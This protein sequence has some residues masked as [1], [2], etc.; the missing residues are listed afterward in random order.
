VLFAR[1]SVGFAVCLGRYIFF[2]SY[3]SSAVYSPSSAQTRIWEWSSV[4]R[5]LLGNP[6]GKINLEGYPVYGMIIL[7][8]ILQKSIR[9]TQSGL[10]WLEIGRNSNL[11]LSWYWNS[12]FRQMR[13]VASVAE[14]PIDF[15]EGL[16]SVC[17]V[18]SLLSLL[19]SS[20]VGCYLLGQLLGY[21]FCYLVVCLVR[22]SASQFVNYLVSQSFS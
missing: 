5:V 11:L 7:K 3:S 8:W 6:E 10:V 19:V 13:G 4:C 21:L 12:G 18:N 22:Q 2:T 1:E 14:W 16:W 9:R 15:E 17:L 20:L